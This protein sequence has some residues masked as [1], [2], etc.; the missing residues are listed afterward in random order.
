[1]QIA[2]MK[3]LLSGGVIALALFTA[4]CAH[5]YYANDPYYGNYHHWSS[6]ETIYYNQWVTEN[7]IDRDYKHLSREDQ[8]R[9]WDW[10]DRHDHDR[11]R[12][13]DRDYDYRK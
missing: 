2:S 3:H 11:D 12:D 7:H 9:Y 5:H 8:R 1:M 4:G 13:H 6:H 10:R